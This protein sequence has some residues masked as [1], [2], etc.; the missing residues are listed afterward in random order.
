MVFS[1]QMGLDGNRINCAS[2]L[3]TAAFAYACWPIGILPGL[4]QSLVLGHRVPGLAWP[5]AH[6][7]ALGAGVV[8][9]FP[10]MLVVAALLRFSLP[11]AQAWALAGVLMGTVFGMVTWRVLEKVLATRRLTPSRVHCP[12][13]ASGEH[14]DSLEGG[15]P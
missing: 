8:V 3:G 9:A 2:T 7:T 11:S 5:A 10:V 13:G 6:L 14:G 4:L 15:V 1:T 12:G